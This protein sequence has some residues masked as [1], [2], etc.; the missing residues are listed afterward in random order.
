MKILFVSSTRSP[1]FESQNPDEHIKYAPYSVDIIGCRLIELGHTVNWHGWKSTHNPLRLAKLINDFK[2]DIIYTYGALVSL[3]PL[4]CRRF[5]CRHKAFS[6]VHGWDD[7][8][9]EIWGTLIGFPGRLVFN[10]LEKMIVTKSDRVVTLSRF[11]Q[12]KGRAW[13]VDCHYIPNGADPVPPEKIKG[14]IKLTGRF[15]LVYTGDKVKWKRTEDICRAMKNLPADIK[16]YLTGRNEDYLKPY[17]SE[18][19]VFLGFL[20]KE[21]QYN[22]MSQADA[23][24]VTADQDCNAK[25]QEYL[26]WRKPILAFDGRANLFFKNG[27]NALLAKDGDYAPLIR[28]LAANPELCKAIADNAASDLPVFSW[29]E[30]ARKF[31]NYF[32]GIIGKKN[33]SCSMA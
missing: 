2:P 7:E 4:F 32:K 13:G 14:N 18:N 8:Y 17:A 15:N 3:H 12:Q 29:L 24:V 23:F 31:E 10:R 27:R 6:V 19:C 16:L 22:V 33:D 26:R 11:L 28:Q 9:G 1:W 25:L 5:L 20:P 21:E 30:I